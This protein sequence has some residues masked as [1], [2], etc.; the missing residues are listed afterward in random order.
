MNGRYFRLRE[1]ATRQE[2]LSDAVSVVAVA[3]EGAAVA[4]KRLKEIESDFDVATDDFLWNNFRD[5]NRA[6][7]DQ[8]RDDV[9][10]WTHR[11]EIGV[12]LKVEAN[13]KNNNKENNVFSKN[14][15]I[16]TQK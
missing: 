8:N 10:D 4:A 3:E 1:D 2:T 5:E 7:L 16:S 15:L 13:L 6:P 11:A 14:Q 12:F 9:K